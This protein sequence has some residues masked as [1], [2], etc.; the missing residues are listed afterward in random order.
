[1]NHPA[2]FYPSNL[3]FSWPLLFGQSITIRPLRPDDIDTEHAFVV[4]L[5]SETRYNRMLGGGSK[6]SR[7]MLERLTRIDF[8]RDMALAASVIVG[9]SESFAGVV[10]YV[11][12]EDQQSCE[13]AVVVADAWQ[14]RGLGEGLLMHLIYAAR[15]AGIRHM[16]GDVFSSNTPMLRLAAKLGFQTTAHA[17]GAQLRR[18]ALDIHEAKALSGLAI[19][20]EEQA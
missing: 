12:L 14:G 3:T 8:R 11:L 13:F 10:R 16:Y 7:V 18:I 6:L 15:R 2:A 4:G 1:M 9:D 20:A 19:Y 5:S 17:E